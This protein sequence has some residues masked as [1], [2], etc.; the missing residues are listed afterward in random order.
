MTINTIFDRCNMIYEKD[1]NHPI[2][3]VERQINFNIA[4][5]PQLINTLDRTINHPLII[6]YSHIPFNN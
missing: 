1:M 4:K 5:N 3:M 6:K 2:T